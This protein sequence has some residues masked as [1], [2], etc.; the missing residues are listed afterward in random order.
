MKAIW[1]IFNVVHLMYIKYKIFHIQIMEYITMS[2]KFGR[3][4][5]S[6]IS[7]TKH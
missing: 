3:N 7:L 4:E 1:L 5:I 6:Q 2:E